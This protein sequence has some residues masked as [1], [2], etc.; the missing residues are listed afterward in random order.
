M[1]ETYV[2]RIGRTGRAGLDGTAISFCTADE[3][4]DFEQI[5]RLTKGNMETVE[6][7]PFPQ[8]QTEP[9]PKEELARIRE[10]R[11]QEARERRARRNGQKNPAPEKQKAAAPAGQT[12]KNP[13]AAPE[14]NARQGQA[15]KNRDARQESVRKDASPAG[16]NTVP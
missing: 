4:A 7:H 14:K 1:P 2:H 6:D 10:Q 11:R 16:R 5:L 13:P 15:P 3:R 12:E 9:T 8:Q